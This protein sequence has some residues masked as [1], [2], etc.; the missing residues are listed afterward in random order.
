M[1]QYL[2][3]AYYYN[4]NYNAAGLRTS[5]LATILDTQTTFDVDNDTFP[6]DPQLGIN[7]ILF[8]NAQNGQTISYPERDTGILVSTVTAFLIANSFNPP[9][10]GPVAFLSGSFLCNHMRYT[11]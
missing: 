2:A 9:P 5:A 10:T 11:H 1:S 6:P 7:K 3:S 4:V 8:I